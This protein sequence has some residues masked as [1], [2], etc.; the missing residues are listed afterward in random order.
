MD[1]SLQIALIGAM[2]TFSV[3]ILATLVN[4]FRERSEKDRWQ[5]SLELEREK[6]QR[7]LEIE[8]R[9]IKH[10]ENKWTLELNNQLEL[11]LHKM[12][13]R[14]YPEV[15]SMLSLLS[16][17]NIDHLTESQAQEFADKLNQWGYGEVGLCMLPDTRDAVFCLRTK[18]MRFV[19][20]EIPTKELIH[21]ERTDLIELMRRDLNHE[22]SV[23]R[24]FKPLID[25]H[26]ESVHK[27]LEE[28]IQYG[29]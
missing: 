29:G 24:K 10:E 12:R 25:L 28:D 18:L 4:Y 16:H 5:R 17:Y 19:R 7:T 1:L 8:E 2:F 22:W 3:G 20:K 27:A 6:W 26:K 21:G 23:W 9:R 13:I 11:E 14:T 15:F